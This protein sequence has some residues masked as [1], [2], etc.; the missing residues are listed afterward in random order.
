MSFKPTPTIHIN[1]KDDVQSVGRISCRFQFEWVEGGDPE[2]HF[3]LL[4][5]LPWWLTSQNSLLDKKYQ[6]KVDDKFPQRVAP[7]EMTYTLLPPYL[8]DEKF[9]W[10]HCSWCG[11]AN[12]K[13]WM[14]RMRCSSCKVRDWIPFPLPSY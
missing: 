10:F 12:M 1:K 4:N 8:G 7:N 6:V 14:G 5:S 9:H 3:S 13:G 11:K 2:T